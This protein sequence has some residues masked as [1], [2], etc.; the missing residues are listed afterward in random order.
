MPQ[1]GVGIRNT[2]TNPTAKESVLDRVERVYIKYLRR[3]VKSEHE[4][5]TLHFWCEC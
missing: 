5:F 2:K 3:A 4:R 1:L